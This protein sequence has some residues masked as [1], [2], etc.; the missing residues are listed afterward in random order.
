[1]YPHTLQKPPANIDKYTLQQPIR[2]K[3][4]AVWE[5]IPHTSYHKSEGLI[6]NIGHGI[7]IIKSFLLMI[8]YMM[9]IPV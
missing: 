2:H 5:K 3:S 9:I 1:M 4:V 8:S 6:G 7:S